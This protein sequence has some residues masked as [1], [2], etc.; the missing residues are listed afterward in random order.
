VPLDSLWRIES[1]VSRV[2]EPSE[3]TT[4]ARSPLVSHCACSAKRELGETDVPIHSERG[5]TDVGAVN[6]T[7]DEGRDHQWQKMPRAPF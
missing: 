5:E 4:M 2:G 6:V 3:L 7:D 1:A